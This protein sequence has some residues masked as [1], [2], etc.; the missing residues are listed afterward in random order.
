MM[1]LSKLQAA[2]AYGALM[3][4]TG[5]DRLFPL[6]VEVHYALGGVIADYQYDGRVS[7]DMDMAK[8]MAAGIAG[9]AG[10]RMLLG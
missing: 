1:T 5:L 3:R 6:P 10:T 7:M 8:N 4:L 9:G 2:A